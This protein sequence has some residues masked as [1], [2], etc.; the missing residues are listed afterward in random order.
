MPSPVE[1]TCRPMGFYKPGGGTCSD[2]RES[3]SRDRIPWPASCSP[4]AI[5]LEDIMAQDKAKSANSRSHAGPNSMHSSDPK[6]DRPKEPPKP[7]VE[8]EMP[9][10]RGRKHEK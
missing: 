2:P 10:K 3:A 8:R 5:D 6:R 7:P 1:L 9:R 4:K